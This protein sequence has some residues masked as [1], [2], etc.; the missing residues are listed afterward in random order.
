MLLPRD[1]ALRFIEGYKA[2]LLRI[3]DDAGIARTRSV[4]DD[5]ATARSHAKDKPEVVDLAITG[6]EADGQP[7]DARII[8]AVKSM[9]VDQWFYLRHTNTFAIFIDKEVEH[10]YQ[11][12]ALTTPL[13]ELIDEPPF[14]FE[15]GLFEYEG[16]YVCDGLVL[17]PVAL[18]PGYKAQ[19]ASAYS[20]IRKAGRLHARTAA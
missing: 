14:T 2:I 6:L 16:G 17:N 4:T 7:V 12:K 18:G 3:L 15:I 13:N 20:A 1:S 10:A 9:K 5:L 8:S 11:V 19:L